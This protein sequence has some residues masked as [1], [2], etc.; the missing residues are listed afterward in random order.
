V[1][2]HP[3]T[4][5]RLLLNGRPYRGEVGHRRLTSPQLG[6]VEASWDVELSPGVNRLS[7]QASST[8]S[9]GLSEEV[10]LAYR[11]AG[12]WMPAS[13][14]HVLAIGINAYPG[15]SKLDYAVAD[16][17]AMAR[18]LQ[19]QEG[20]GLY[21]QVHVRLLTDEHARRQDIVQG[22]RW[23]HDR[24]RPTD[25]AL[26]FYAG[27]GARDFRGRFY[28]LPS[29][30]DPRSLTRQG[31][32]EDELKEALAEVPG[33]VLLLLDACQAGKV[34]ELDLVGTHKRGLGSATDD[35][36]RLLSAEENGVVV[37]CA[38][39]GRQE[40]GESAELGHGY[41]TLALLE[42]LAGKADYNKDGLVTLTELDNYV[43]ER[44]L[45]LSQGEQTAC[46]AKSTRTGSFPIVRP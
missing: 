24:V 39:Q 46:T 35:L 37:M 34:G 7:V 18:L 33:K 45:E 8:V 40:S 1:G 16:A 27:H 43:A 6:E 4:S 23:L 25:V 32:S 44:V 31:V 20:R 29:D 28:L 19:G 38:A 36:L 15:A 14:L 2:E 10:V 26:V 13:D 5:L 42:G 9:V 30:V 22:L 12:S 3:V 41:F 11:P 17:E 21:R